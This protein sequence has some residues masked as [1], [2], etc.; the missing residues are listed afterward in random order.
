MKILLIGSGNV[1]HH[2]YSKW[3]D[4]HD[5]YLL[6]R[7]QTLGDEWNET[8]GTFLLPEIPRQTFD[9]TVVAVKDD[10]ISETL[11]WGVQTK[12]IVHTSGQRGME[13]FNNCSYTNTGIFYPLQTF[14]KGRP[15][16]FTKIPFILEAEN[17]QT[18]ELLQ[19]LVEDWGAQSIQL[20]TEEKR[21]IHLAAVWV[22]NYTNY[23]RIIGQQQIPEAHYKLLEPL[24]YETL[25]KSIE[26]GVLEAQTG[27]ARRKDTATIEQHAEMMSGKEK[28]LYLQIAKMIM[29]DEKL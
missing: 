17:A 22:S 16:D 11:T 7:K 27:P 21:K 28:E 9:L 10:A 8:T 5:V 15:L 24:M 29:N 12:A 18:L 25:S 4:T 1:A 20:S 19:S 13:V 23:M 2:F 3:K 6:H 26:W 14:T